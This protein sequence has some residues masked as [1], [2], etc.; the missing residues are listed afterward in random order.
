M[1]NLFQLYD[2]DDR[3]ALK[4][5]EILDFLEEKGT[6]IDLV[7]IMI[8]SISLVNGFKTIITNNISH[9]NRIPDISKKNEYF[10]VQILGLMILYSLL[11]R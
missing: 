9:F 1:V 2:Y 6:I 4:T 8:A 7:D 5:A 11:K 3:A 10:R